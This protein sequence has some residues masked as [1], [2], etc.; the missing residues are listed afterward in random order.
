[1]NAGARFVV[2]GTTGSFTRPQLESEPHTHI[3]DS[4]AALPTLR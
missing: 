1:M 4:V 3:F 2:G